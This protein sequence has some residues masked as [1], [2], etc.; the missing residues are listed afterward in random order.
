MAPN[1]ES[2]QWEDTQRQSDI[3]VL[4]ILDTHVGYTEYVQRKPS[5]SSFSHFLSI[6]MF[7]MS[8]RL[9]TLNPR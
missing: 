5:S 3:E 4:T 6:T 1:K 9:G 8:L 7:S 2:K